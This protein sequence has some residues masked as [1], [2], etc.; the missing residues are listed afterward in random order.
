MDD[1]PFSERYGFSPPPQVKDYDHL[2][3]WV[4]EAII[5]GVAGFVNDNASSS[6]QNIDFYQLTRPY[7]WQVLDREPPRNPMGGPWAFYIPTTLMKCSWWQFYDILEQM[8]RLV[9]Q[10]WGEEYSNNLA[11][12]VNAPLAREVIPWKIEKGKIVHSFDPQIQQHI[13]K[14]RVL[15]ADPRFKGPDEQFEKAIACLN[16]RPDPD[17]ENCVKD[18]VGAIEAVANILAGTTGVQLNRLLNQQPF[19]TR[20]HSTIRQSIEKIYAYRGAAPGVGHGQV[21][22]SV[23]GIAEA[24]WVLA[25]S[26][27]TI[28][29]LVAKFPQDP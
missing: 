23:V 12:K 2:P 9:E 22:P 3:P 15:L 4:R 8:T 24:T 7:I 25:T 10:Q 28:L 6:L 13:N 26:A 14:A 20:I 5:N 1:L 17:E 16:R 19:E 11:E 29:Y 27:A 21:G 18:A